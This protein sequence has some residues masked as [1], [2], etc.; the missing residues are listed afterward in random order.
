MSESTTTTTT[1]T[2]AQPQVVEKPALTLTAIAK[3]LLAGG[4][5]GGVCVH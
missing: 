1:T 2:S 3:S 5:A 4:V